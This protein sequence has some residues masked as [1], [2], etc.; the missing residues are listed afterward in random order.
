MSHDRR[1]WHWIIATPIKV[2]HSNLRQSKYDGWLIFLSAFEHRHCG[3]MH[4]LST[5]HVYTKTSMYLQCDS[6]ILNTNYAN[7]LTF[8]DGWFWVLTTWLLIGLFCNGY[9]AKFLKTEVEMAISRVFECLFHMAESIHQ[10]FR[11]LLWF[12]VSSQSV[13]VDA[14]HF[15]NLA[16]S[17]VY[18]LFVLCVS[19]PNFATFIFNIAVHRMVASELALAM[20]PTRQKRKCKV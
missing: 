2:G 17:L 9:N 18:M 7:F 11:Y 20:G 6:F 5:S 16:I 10:L 13:M 15:P 4:S 12:E 19:K 1:K 3:V 14:L 8:T